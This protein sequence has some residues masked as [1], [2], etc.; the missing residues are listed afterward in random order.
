MGQ[1][2]AQ[3]LSADIDHR[4]RHR[5]SG[6]EESGDED[7][8]RRPRNRDLALEPLSLHIGLIALAIVIGW[9]MLEALVWLEQRLLIPLGWPELMPHIP[10]FPLA[11]IGGVI[12][13]SS[14]SSAADYS[15]PRR[16]R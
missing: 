15:P 11:M 4:G 10:L 16:C 1:A 3:A 12:V 6:S 13:S 14:P 2:A 8:P 9:C 7:Q 5:D